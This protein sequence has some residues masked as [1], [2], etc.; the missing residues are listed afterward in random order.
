MEQ[1]KK[2]LNLEHF[3][4]LHALNIIINAYRVKSRPVCHPI[5]H[6][7]DGKK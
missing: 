1:A 3:L 6:L 5:T 7:C 2:T 4:P